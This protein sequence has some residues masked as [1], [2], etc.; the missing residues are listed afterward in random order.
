MFA[1]NR[2][3]FL[4]AHSATIAAMKRVSRRYMGRVSVDH[5][6]DALNGAENIKISRATVARLM[7]SIHFKRRTLRAKPLVSS[8]NAALRLQF[9]I[10]RLKH[11]RGGRNIHI[12][13]VDVD[14]KYFS[15]HEDA[16]LVLPAEDAT[17]TRSL[18]SK[19]NRPKV[20]LLMAFGERYR[21]YQCQADQ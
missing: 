8:K 9:A 1:A 17:P 5:M 18:Q 11:A 13:H 7:T 3:L 21:T 15:A 2:S 14:E 10:D 12:A 20:M 4:T 6:T 16:R 19:R